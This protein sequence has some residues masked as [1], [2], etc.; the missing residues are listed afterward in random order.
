MPDRATPHYLTLANGQ[1]RLWQRGAGPDLVVLGG[2]TRAAEVLANE[3][4]LANPGCR[5]TALELPGI[6]GSRIEPSG[7]A[8][9]AADHVV[10]ALAS[11]AELALIAHEMAAGLLPAI[12]RK[13]G[14]EVPVITVGLERSLAWRG[15]VSAE[16]D[17]TPRQDGTHLTLLWHHLRDRELLE[18]ENTGQ[19]A[20]VGEPI[21]P[22]EDL[23]ATFVAAATM[24]SGYARLWSLCHRTIGEAAKLEGCR[25]VALLSDVAG[26][27]AGLRISVS[28]NALPPARALP[29]NAIWHDSIMTSRGLMHLR[30][31]GEGGRP[32]LVIPTGG[33]S[34]A[35]FAPVVSGLA[36]G[37]QVF[38]VDYFG[39][40]L[41]EKLDRDVTIDMLAE[42]MAALIEA[43]GF[44]EVDV[45]GSHTGSLVALELAVTRPDLVRRAVLE[46]P[47]FIDPDF[48]A[49]LLDNYFPQI[50]PDKW[51]LHLQLAWHWR[52]DMFMYWPWYRV[53]RA[54]ARD[55]GVPSAED[56]HLYTIGILES[57]LT[58]DQAY[59]SAFKYDTVR[60]LPLL[61]RQALICAGPNDMLVNGVEESAKLNV[62]SVETT[63]TPT[64]VWWPAPEAAAAQATLD[65]YDA[66]L[67][68]P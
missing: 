34:S 55:L 63:L 53:D 56:L 60:R 36:R 51:G 62:P 1:I 43:L 14:R 42:D 33:G 18:P 21:S 23:S 25:H 30:R 11:F 3:L 67:S 7:D 17:I 6:G 52:R 8:E 38:A 65:L 68:R 61:K 44:Q 15:S 31:A 54:A 10:K 16:L 41:S 32:L 22:A 19:P 45:W 47:V 13:L 12:L 26:A 24:P 27:L 40:G 20:K 58:Y 50:R 66:F 28:G 48:Q 59:R 35:Q 37:R 57:G 39:N 5:V 46:G 2:L 49:D 29:N 9:M 4:A 64:T